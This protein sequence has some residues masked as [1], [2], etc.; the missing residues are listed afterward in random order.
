MCEIMENLM[1]NRINEEKIKSA[2][3]AI[4]SDKY[5]L[6]AIAD[7]VRLPMAFVQEL[8]NVITA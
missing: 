5:T 7:I 6:E 1:E 4:A 3:Q 8:A 2:K